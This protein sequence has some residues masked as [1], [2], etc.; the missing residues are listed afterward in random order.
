[1]R[2]KHRAQRLGGAIA[3]GPPVLSVTEAPAAQ[4]TVSRVFLPA[5]EILHDLRVAQKLVTAPQTLA[6]FIYKRWMFQCG[7]HRESRVPG[8]RPR[9]GE[10]H[11]FFAVLPT[12][13]LEPRET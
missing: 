7:L 11:A 12:P 10:A 4:R 2:R 1:M 13:A 5:L 3:H 6:L 9:A 8:I